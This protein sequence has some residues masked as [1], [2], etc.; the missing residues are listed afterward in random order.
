MAPAVVPTIKPLNYIGESDGQT[1]FT[2]HEDDE[3]LI[4]EGRG[5]EE[6]EGDAEWRA[7]LEQTDENR[8]GGAGAEGCDGAEE[9]GDKVPPDAACGS[10]SA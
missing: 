3:V 9:G 8:H 6:G 10:S 2:G 1:E 7:G 4:D 5:D